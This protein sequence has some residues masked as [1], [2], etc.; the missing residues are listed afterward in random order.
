MALT[1]PLGLDTQQLRCE[2]S[3]IY[4]RVAVNPQGNFPFPRGPTYAAEFLGY[5]ATELASIPAEAT[6]S[7]AGVGNP[8]AIA[9]LNQGETVLDIGCGAG[10]DLLLAARRVGPKGRAIGVEMTEAMT[11]RVRNAA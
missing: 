4:A 6:A 7:F 10:T 8:L 1:C 2:V 11:E 3:N 5:D 9:P